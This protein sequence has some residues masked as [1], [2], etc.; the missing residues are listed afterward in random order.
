[1]SSK[2]KDILFKTATVAVSLLACGMSAR[3]DN[4]TS[5]SACYYEPCTDGYGVAAKSISRSNMWSSDKASAIQALL[6]NA[7]DGY[8]RSIIAIVNSNMWSSDKL[9]AIKKESTKFVK[10]IEV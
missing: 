5:R 9:D 3:L 2:I 6:S 4:S 7:P 1:M 8:Y 10:I